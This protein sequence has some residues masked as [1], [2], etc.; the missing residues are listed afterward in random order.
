MFVRTMSMPTPRP[1][2]SD[3]ALAVESP[4]KKMYWTPASSLAGQRFRANKPAFN[5]FSSQRRRVDAPARRRGWTGRS[6]TPW[7]HAVTEIVPDSGLPS[8]QAFRRGFD[9]VVDGV[10]EDVYERVRNL[11][12]HRPV[13]LGFLAGGDKLRPSCRTLWRHRARAAAGATA[14]VA[15]AAC[16]CA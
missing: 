6:R 15:W 11:L 7:F 8:C 13:Q 1:D 2:T 12:D 9:A 4:A 16:G 14:P 3:S 5:R 10:A